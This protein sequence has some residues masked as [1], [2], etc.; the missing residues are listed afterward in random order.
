MGAILEPTYGDIQAL[1]KRIA[2]LERKVETLIRV[3]NN[4]QERIT[5]LENDFDE[6]VD[7]ELMEKLDY[8][9]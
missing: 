9:R 1:A 7:E 3:S 8:N 2:D 6:Y 5:T 4:A